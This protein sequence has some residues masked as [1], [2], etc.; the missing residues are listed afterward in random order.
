[1][2]LTFALLFGG[3]S[4]PTAPAPP[5][6][7]NTQPPPPPPPPAPNVAPVIASITASRSRAEVEDAIVITAAV[8]DAETP[9]E[10]LKYA[11]AV[12]VGEITGEGRVVTV[13][14]PRNTKPTPIELK[15][16]LTVT[17]SYAGTNASGQLATLE[18]R[19]VQSATLTRVHD[20]AAELSA[21]SL[22]F[23]LDLFGNSRV[24]AD[25]CV[26]DFWTGCPGKDAE[27]DD[28]KNN[29]AEFLILDASAKVTAVNVDGARTNAS[30]DLACEFRDRKLPNGTEGVSK[31]TCRLTAVYQNN[32]WWLCTS[33]FEGTCG[34]CA[35]PQA[36][37]QM[38]MREFFLAGHR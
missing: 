13:K 3:C 25:Q 38:S 11:W 32:R 23:L 8:T 14:V 20:S 15:V 29:R 5:A 22:R 21:M 35:T 10:N 19:V 33:T 6:P 18:H 4:A 26:V 27:L 9:V 12:E 2:V 1:M 34:S 31:G 17:E 16:T 7:P 37:R 36:V 24:P 28:I 30:I